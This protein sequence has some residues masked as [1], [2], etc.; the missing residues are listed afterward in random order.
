MDSAIVAC[1]LA[2]AM[3]NAIL[4]ALI[5]FYVGLPRLRHEFHADSADHQNDTGAC[6]TDETEPAVEEVSA[7]PLCF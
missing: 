5:V 1:T 7:S 4:F 2:L 3:G 6:R